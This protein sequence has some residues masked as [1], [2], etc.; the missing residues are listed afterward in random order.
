MTVRIVA[1]PASRCRRHADLVIIPG[2]KATRADLAAL[3]QFGWD[4]DILAH[5]R[6]GKRVLGLCGGYQMLGKVV[7][8]PLGIE[9]APGETPGLGLLDVETTLG[10]T[11]QL[12][13][14]SAT[15]VASGLAVSGYHMHMGVTDGPDCA[16]PFAHI[17]E[18]SEGATAPDGR[19]EGTY[20]HG[21]FAENAFRHAFLKIKSTIG[22]EHGVDRTLDDL[23]AHLTR[24]IDLDLLLDLAR[25]A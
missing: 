1:P 16:R 19:V 2:S 8:D 22:Y 23:A 12:R 7:R 10:D 24:H 4:I 9:G 20:L 5:H 18:T 6:A 14:E 15:H 17:G 13:V 21:L 3:R 25:E 11:K